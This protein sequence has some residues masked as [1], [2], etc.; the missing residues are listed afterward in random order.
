MMLSIVLNINCLIILSNYLKIK[1]E[2]KGDSCTNSSKN[3]MS[4]L[5]VGYSDVLHLLRLRCHLRSQRSANKCFQDVQ[6]LRKPSSNVQFEMFKVFLIHVL[7]WQLLS[8]VKIQFQH[9][10]HHL[11]KQVGINLIIMKSL[12]QSIDNTRRKLDQSNHSKT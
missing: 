2:K 8:I 9:Y 4:V 3:N 6:V 7:V 10:H 12:S 1:G 11:V 5:Y